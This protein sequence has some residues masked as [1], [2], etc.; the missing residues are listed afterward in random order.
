M[1]Y[2]DDYRD[3]ENNTISFDSTSAENAIASLVQDYPVV[4]T[5]DAQGDYGHLH[6]VFVHNCVTKYHKNVI[7]F[8]P[9]GQGNLTVLLP[10]D[11]YSTHE[12]P[13]HYASIGEFIS[14]LNRKNEYRVPP[15]LLI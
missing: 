5:H 12:I 11:L 7:T 13:V 14:P 3:L 8:S 2:V 15:Y 1:G 6:H 10:D 9:F 4:V